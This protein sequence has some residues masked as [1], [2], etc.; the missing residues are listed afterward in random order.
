MFYMLP[1]TFS[2]RAIFRTLYSLFIL[3][4]SVVH[5]DVSKCIY[6]CRQRQNKACIDGF[7]T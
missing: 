4:N 5:V 7:Q 3:M 6:L 2:C 1:E